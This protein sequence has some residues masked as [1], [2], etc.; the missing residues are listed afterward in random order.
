MT[1]HFFSGAQDDGGERRES[2]AQDDG[3]DARTINNKEE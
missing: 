2:G 3:G 1:V